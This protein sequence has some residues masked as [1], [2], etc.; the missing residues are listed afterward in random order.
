MWSEP[1]GPKVL[2]NISESGVIEL[3]TRKYKFMQE[4]NRMLWRCY[5]ESYKNVS[6][7]MERMHLLSNEKGGRDIT[8]QR[9]RTEVQNIENEKLL[10]DLEIGKIVWQAEKKKI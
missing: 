5:F 1:Q 4:E 10:S 2:D 8:K 3:P 6:G 7:Y 9:L